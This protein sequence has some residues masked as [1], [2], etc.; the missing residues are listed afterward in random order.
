MANPNTPIVN[1][2]IKYVNGL[3]IQKIDEF[4][5]GIFP[6]AARDSLNVNDI[7]LQ[8][9]V[10]TDFT[11]IGINGLDYGAVERDQR[12]SVYIVGDS[13]NKNFTGG[14]LS[15]N[16]LNPILPSGYD[17]YR[18]IGYIKTGNPSPSILPFVQNGE[19]QQRSFYYGNNIP[20]LLIG[21]QT[22]FTFVDLSE[23]VPPI[24]TD[25]FC[26]F[27]YLPRVATNYAQFLPLGIPTSF[28]NNFGLIQFSSG[29]ID[30][31]KY[32]LT[33]PCQIDPN[34]GK[35]GFL[36]KVFLNDNLYIGV[37]GY[38]DILN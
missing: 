2:G 8:S 26:F 7:I 11:K 19:G 35:P 27:N 29:S 25:V 1:A 14:L 22:N 6:G 10:Y 34:T 23:A 18:R 9:F 31:Q 4:V 24:A 37:I 32:V 15:K 38:K 17:M 28:P 5:V 21:N 12:Y 13:T 20:V 30:I 33:I 3:E 36:Y 16:F